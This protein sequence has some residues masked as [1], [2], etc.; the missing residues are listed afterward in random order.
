MPLGNIGEAVR[1]QPTFEVIDPKIT[2]KD[3]YI[4]PKNKE[5]IESVI[6]GIERADR[7]G[8]MNYSGI[9]CLGPPGT[10]KT[11]TVQYMAYRTK[12]KFINVES[13]S[14]PDY[15]KALYDFAGKQTEDN[16]RKVLIFVD[17]IDRVSSRD[18]IID[19]S[20]ASTLNQFLMRLDGVKSNQNIFTFGATNKPDKLD[21]ALRRGKRFG[22]EIEFWPPDEDG[23]YN[24]LKIHA[25]PCIKKHKFEVKDKDLKELSKI[26]YGYT[27]ADLSAILTEAFA[28]ANYKDRLKIEF[29][30]LEYA[31]K[32][33]KPAAIRDMPFVEP[34]V[35]LDD[36]AGYENHKEI[37]KRIIDSNN[38][39]V[40]LLYGPDG[41]GKTKMTEALAKNYGYNFV[42]V[43]A[44]SP[45]EGIV[46]QTEKKIEKY[47]DRAKQLA[48]CILVF[49]KIDALV[50]PKDTSSW[51]TSWTGVIESRLG[52]PADG[53][54]TFAI[55]TNPRVLR[56]TL[57][58]LF[59]SRIYVPTPCKEDRKKI[60]DY[61]LCKENIDLNKV[62]IDTEKLAS[63]DRELSC[64][65]I[66][67]IIDKVRNF[68]LSPSEEIYLELTKEEPTDGADEDWASV[69]KEIGD[70][71]TDYTQVKR[72]MKGGGKK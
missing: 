71:V 11:I 68:G 26:T 50:E 53:V 69:K 5:D 2:E 60:W 40:T 24:I 17:E 64:V 42:I 46:G 57:M 67:Q 22:K 31:L 56:D 14:G 32:K 8:E 27:G 4:H 66:R 70:M 12:A 49:D 21:N 18:D 44:S 6:K 35:T 58:Q 38:S 62:K 20:Q 51:R 10:G 61:Y 30:D 43:P 52:R 34:S 65:D 19:P 16:K 59:G 39:S 48:P 29:S 9:L 47:F 72:F 54:H 55:A 45:L 15:I 13:F 7:F 63:V 3:L 25:D 36:I 1:G 28:Y 33:I 41:N 37:L 23:R